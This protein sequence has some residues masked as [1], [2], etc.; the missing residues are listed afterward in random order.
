[1][2]REEFRLVLPISLQLPD[3]NKWFSL[4]FLRRAIGKAR[5][6]K[7]NSDE[8][9]VRDWGDN[10][11]R[12]H[13]TL[14]EESEH[15]SGMRFSSSAAPARQLRM[16]KQRTLFFDIDNST[17]R[18]PKSEQ[19][20]TTACSGCTTQGTPDVGLNIPSSDCH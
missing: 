6:G 4:E 8:A 15:R 13:R 9:G 17:P 16:D 19:S 11:H 10:V 2:H 5:I 12:H 20:W 3:I 18:F 1:L 7:D 14:V